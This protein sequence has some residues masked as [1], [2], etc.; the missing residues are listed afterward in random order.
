MEQKRQSK[1]TRRLLHSGLTILVLL[2]VLA[3][4]IGF[5]VLSN[6]QLLRLDMSGASYNEISN[7]S[8]T[9]LDQLDPDENN[10]TIYFLADADELRST[11]LDYSNSYYKQ[12]GYDTTGNLWGMK[13]IYDIALEFANEYEFV[14]VKHLPL[15]KS[16]QELDAFRSTIGTELTKQDVIVDNYTAE[17]DANGKDVLD[18][19]GNPVMH[20][21]FRIIKRD[22]FFVFDSETSYVF[23]FQGDLR[24]TANI[25]SLSGANPTVYF[26]TG[27]GEAVGDY[28]AG[29]YSSSGDYGEAQALRDLFFDAGFTTKKIDLSKEADK[30]FA[31]ESARILVIYGPETDF[32]GE[33]AAKDGG[34]NEVALLRHFLV[35]EDH[36]LMAFV[37]ETKEPLSNLESYLYDYWGVAFEDALIKDSGRNS[38][39]DNG[40]DFLGAY[41]TDPYSIGVNLTDQLTKLDSYPRAAFSNA[42][43]MT[44]D[45][46]F[47][48]SVG[49]SEMFAGLTAGAV[50]LAPEGTTL[51]DADGKT[52]SD[53]EQKGS[54]LATLTYESFNTDHS[55]TVATYVFACGG[56]GFASNELIS[57]NAYA[58][59]DV[60]YY[61]MRL[62][63]R[64]TVPFD[65]DFK[66]MDKEGL[67]TITDSEALSWTIVICSLVPLGS[68]ALGTVVFIKRRHS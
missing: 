1:L 27:H 33:A 18:E 59:R 5:T 21:N 39:S 43:P 28:K 35:Q 25:L 52:L 48:Q 44:L 51:V 42:R 67:D 16:V 62:M 3:V 49:Y 26:V 53:A 68:L 8:R 17:K 40:M 9:L 56:T 4:N 32:A 30:L 50:F 11:Y 14:S 20:H 12:M 10:I 24:F 19:N 66:V 15:H 36:H 47:V 22:A 65:I 58:N 31:D 41:E 29:E 23:G 6:S 57:N 55:D 37:G 45:P 38:L 7:E 63:S 46:N 54:I 64:D 13:Y 2:A 61:T 34:V 60:L